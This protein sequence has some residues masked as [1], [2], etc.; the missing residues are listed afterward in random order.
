MSSRTTVWSGASVTRAVAA[1]TT[2]R[3]GVA[4]AVLLT[5]ADGRKVTVLEDHVFRVLSAPGHEGAA[6]A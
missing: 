4:Y 5:Q 3:S 1:N 2:A 6:A